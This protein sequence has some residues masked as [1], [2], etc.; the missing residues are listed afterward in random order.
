MYYFSMNSPPDSDTPQRLFFLDWLR[1]IAFVTLVFYHVGMYYVTWDFHVKSPFAGHGLEPWMKLTEPWRISL[2]FV[3]SGAAT[4][5][6]FKCGAAGAL[7]RARSRFVLLPLLCGVVLVVPPQSY[8]EVMQKW[9]YAGS[10]FDFLALYF[11]HYKG[12]C[13]SGHCLVLPT[14]NHLWFLPYLWGY[15]LMLWALL[16]LWPN[17]LAAMSLRV[18]RALTG[19]WLM[20]LPMVVIFVL[21]VMLFARYPSTHAL[22]GDGFNHAVYFSMFLTGACFGAMPVLWGRLAAWRWPALIAALGFWAGLVGVRPGGWAEHAVVAVFQWSALVTVFG[23][24]QQR[25]NVDHPLRGH[26]VEAV[27]PVYIF[28]QTLIIMLSQW[29]LPLRWPPWVEGPVLVLATLVLSYAGYQTVRRV[30]VLRPWFGLRVG[31]KQR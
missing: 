20:L 19:V 28:H 16:R 14:W 30:A 18:A 4:A 3:V 25:L 11:S 10:Y 13:Q 31:R 1:I 21:R 2:L 22:W 7:L 15:T 8:L 29:L 5:H 26:L 9:D 17:A 24:A 12:F 27:F 6:L 23:F